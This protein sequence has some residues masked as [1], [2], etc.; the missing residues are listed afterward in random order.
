MFVL[1]DVLYV[2]SYCVS[3]YVDE[4][5]DVIWFVCMCIDDDLVVVI[6]LF[7]FVYE[8]GLSCF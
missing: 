3:Y 6:F 4:V 5:F 8:M 7:D 2:V 1:V